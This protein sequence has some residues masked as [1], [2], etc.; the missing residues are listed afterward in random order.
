M[1]KIIVFT[2]LLLFLT[3]CSDTVVYDQPIGEIADVSEYGL[4][5]NEQ[6][7]VI[8]VAGIEKLIKDKKTS[9]V[10]IGKSNCVWCECLL[11]ILNDISEEHQMKVYMLNTDDQDD[12]EATISS[13]KAIMD[14]FLDNK[15]IETEN[16]MFV[17][18]II[19]I[20]KGKVIARHTGTVTGHNAETQPEMT[21]NQTTRLKYNLNKE[22][23]AILIKQKSGVTL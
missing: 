3:G 2:V 19:Y 18:S 11:P 15:E 23:D 13:L 10:L 7:I 5:D 20:Q 14:G 6:F 1:K 17:P 12:P 16:V 22:F 21:E 9:V 4:V 8:D